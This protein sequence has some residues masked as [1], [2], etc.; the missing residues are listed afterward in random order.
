MQPRGHAG[1]QDRRHHETLGSSI[2]L[3]AL[4][5]HPLGRIV[6]V[7]PAAR[8][9]FGRKVA[10]GYFYATACCPCCMRGT[11]SRARSFAII[12]TVDACKVHDTRLHLRMQRLPTRHGTALASNAIRPLRDDSCDPRRACAT[13]AS[14]GSGFFQ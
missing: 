13:V 8:E 10:A 14:V 1:R 12:F 7:T 11:S 2:S 3:L 6:P 9:L 4:V 5:R